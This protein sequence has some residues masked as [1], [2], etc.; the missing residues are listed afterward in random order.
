MTFANRDDLRKFFNRHKVFR[1][2][3]VA[4]GVLGFIVFITDLP[5]VIGWA[6]RPWKTHTNSSVTRTVSTSLVIKPITLMTSTACSATAHCIWWEICA[7]D[8]LTSSVVQMELVSKTV[9]DVW[10]LT[11]LMVGVTSWK[12]WCEFGIPN[13]QLYIPVKNDIL[14]VFDSH[15]IQ[16]GCQIIAA[17]RSRSRAGIILGRTLTTTTKISQG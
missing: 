1:N 6:K 2:I 4:L 13:F 8:T 7:E 17:R 3:Y 16:L 14:R 12:N 11:V 9:L 10:F 15:R 5:V